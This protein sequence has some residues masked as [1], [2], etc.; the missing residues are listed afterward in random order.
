V[1]ARRGQATTEYFVLLSALV[2]GLLVAAYAFLP[3]FSDGMDDM[4][5]DATRLLSAGTQ[6]GHGDKR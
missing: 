4:G 3:S 6:D 2:I 5:D 1:R